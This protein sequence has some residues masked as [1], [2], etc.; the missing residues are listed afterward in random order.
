MCARSVFFG[1]SFWV[2]WGGG[3][4]GSGVGEINNQKK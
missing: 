2:G 1:S 3:G 4:G